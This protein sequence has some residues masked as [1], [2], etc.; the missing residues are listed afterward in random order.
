[1]YEMTKGNV[2]IKMWIPPLE[3]ESGALD[4]ALN[5]ANHPMVFDHVALMPDVHQGV[6][7]PIGSVAGMTAVVP[8]MCGVDIGCGMIAAKTNLVRD[9][10]PKSLRKRIVGD[11]RKVV[12]VG[13]NHHDDSHPEWMPETPDLPQV[14]IV[15]LQWDSATRQ[16]GTLGGGK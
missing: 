7:A 3:V 8:S 15:R 2:P 14:P 16:V 9:D 6:G 10:L 1:M 12:P 13:F 4:Q 5:I 11:I